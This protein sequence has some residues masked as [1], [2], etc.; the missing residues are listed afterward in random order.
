MV[1]KIINGIYFTL[2]IVYFI[3]F[4][5]LPFQLFK[6]EYWREILPALDLIILYCIGTK[7]SIKSWHLFIIGLIIDPLYNLPTGSTSLA[8][9]LGNLL[10]SFL[11]QWFLVKE[12][13]TDLMIFCMY[14]LFIIIFKFLIITVTNLYNIKGSNVLF[15]YLTTILA[16]PTCKTLLEKPLE[17]LNYYVQ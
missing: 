13:Y 6:L 5:F 1:T 15:Y 7:T 14:S 11:E 2:I 12:Y 16:Y 4:F 17:K 3:L 10:I 8:L 9:I